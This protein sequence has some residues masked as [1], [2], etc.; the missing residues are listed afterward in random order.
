MDHPKI[1]LDLIIFQFAPIVTTNAV[2]R[3]MKLAFWP[4]ELWMS[5]GDLFQLQP[6]KLQESKRNM[7]ILKRPKLESS[8]RCCF[9]HSNKNSKI[10][11][12]IFFLIQLMKLRLG[13]RKPQ[14]N[15][16]C[17]GYKCQ[18]I[19]ALIANTVN[20]QFKNSFKS[21]LQI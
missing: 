15:C 14:S 21:K 10:I 3:Q 5:N 9:N 1:A 17:Q 20:E 19:V 2:K 18:E 4:L 13:K 12:E 11:K 16:N 8:G 7:L 6:L